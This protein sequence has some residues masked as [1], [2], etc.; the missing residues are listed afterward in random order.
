LSRSSASVAFGISVSRQEIIE[1][2]FDA[3]VFADCPN[4]ET[5]LAIADGVTEIRE[6]EFAGRSWVLNVSIP[7]SVTN[8]AAN[9]FAG[10]TGIRNVAVPQLVLD[11]RLSNVFPD[12]YASI[13]RVT[14]LDGATSI[15]ASA[16]AGLPKTT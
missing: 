15:P 2:C 4:I 13:A 9:A 11:K 3:S 14:I 7:A 1:F 5:D 16:F 12:A 8:I 6:G 10:C